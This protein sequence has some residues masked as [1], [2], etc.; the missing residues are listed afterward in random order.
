MPATADD[1]IDALRAFRPD[2]VGDANVYTLNQILEPYYNAGLR[3]HDRVIPVLFEVMERWPEDDL[4]CPGPLVHCIEGQPLEDYEPLLL[5]SF[6]RRPVWLTIW[7]VNRIL[8]TKRKGDD[9]ER[10]LAALRSVA[11]HPL[12]S[13]FQKESAARFLKVQAERG[14]E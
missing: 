3:E 10:L 4:G 1:I 9:R 8:N 6:R 2:F 13:E 5:Q 14:A 11:E 7:M 12:A